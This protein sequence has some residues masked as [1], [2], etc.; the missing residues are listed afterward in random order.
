MRERDWRGLPEKM[1]QAPTRAALCM[2]RRL[3][4]SRLVAGVQAPNMREFVRCK[5][6][7][8]HGLRTTAAEMSS[9]STLERKR[10]AC[11][12]SRVSQIRHGAL[13]HHS[14]PQTLCLEM[15]LDEP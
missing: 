8:N 13:K 5:W 6:D 7:K 10:G 12:T 1:G 14:P 9:D 15:F 3:I 4:A 2:Q 11:V